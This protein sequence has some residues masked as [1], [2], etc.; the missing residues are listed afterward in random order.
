M[1]ACCCPSPKTLNRERVKKVP[2]TS[3]IDPTRTRTGAAKV[4]GCEGGL[5]VGEVKAAPS[6]KKKTK[7]NTAKKKKKNTPQG[8]GKQKKNKKM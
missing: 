7:Q 4:N 3:R 2:L 5:G 6:V 8:A 1:K